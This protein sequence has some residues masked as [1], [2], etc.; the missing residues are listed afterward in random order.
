MMQMVSMDAVRYILKKYGHMI[1]GDAR[2]MIADDL[3]QRAHVCGRG[4]TI[5]EIRDLVNEVTAE[6]CIWDE[7]RTGT[8]EKWLDKKQTEIMM[9]LNLLIE[10]D[11]QT[12]DAE[13]A[14][15]E[16]ES[17]AMDAETADFCREV[18]K[19]AYAYL[20][21]KADTAEMMRYYSWISAKL[22]H[23]RRL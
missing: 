9:K 1:D 10:I 18:L 22:K 23:K 13:D 11:P 14:E 20:I 6:E 4:E 3:G 16:P 12:G 21:D 15:E 5:S 19:G 17:G 7:M 8:L 2:E